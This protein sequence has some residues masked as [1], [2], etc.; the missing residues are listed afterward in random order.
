MKILHIA[1]SDARNGKD[2]AAR[3]LHEELLKRGVDSELWVFEQ[4]S[5]EL[6]VHG[7]A[8]DEKRPDVV[9]R[10]QELQQLLLLLL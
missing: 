8:Q 2:S 4:T 6:G 7:F 10:N 5:R 9:L 1:R 3:I